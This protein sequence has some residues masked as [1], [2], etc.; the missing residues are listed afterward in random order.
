MGYLV[1]QTRVASL[2]VGGNDYTSS[3]VSWVAN[4]ASVNK[5]GYMMTDGELI[6]GQRQGA[7]DITDYDRGTFKRGTPV[8]LRMRDQSGG[9]HTHPRGLLYIISVS[10]D[11]EAEKLV[12]DLGCKIALGKLTDDYEE[13]LD[14]APLPLDKSQENINSIGANFYTNGEF[15]WMDNTGELRTNK[16][17]GTDSSAGIQGGAWTSVLGT[18]TL[19]VNPLAGGKPIPDQIKLSYDTPLDILPTDQTG[20]VDTT[21]TT[22]TYFLSY[23]AIT[24]ERIPKEE[25]CFE[26]GPDGRETPIGCIE[27]A[28]GIVETEQPE[29]ESGC[30]NTPPPPEG[31]TPEGETAKK[32][33]CNSNYKSVPSPTFVGVLRT[34]IQV[35]E[36]SAPGAQISRQSRV[37][38]GPSFELNSQYYSD[39]FAYCKAVYAYSCLPDGACPFKGLSN[40]KQG[41]QETIYYY[42]AEANNLIRT[43]QDTYLTKLSAA[44]PFNWR[45]GIENGVP[46]LFN[47]NIS[48][49]DMYRSERVITE[50]FQEANTNVQITTRFTSMAS[51]GVGINA[52]NLD[53]L[54][55]IKTTEKRVSS[56]TTTLDIRPDSINTV[57]TKTETEEI[58]IN[59]GPD[60]Y[61]SSPEQAGPYIIEEQVPIPLLYENDA[62]CRKI[63]KKYGEYL[64]RF[65]IGDLYG[66]QISESLRDE[67]LTSWYPGMPF[68]YVDPSADTIIALRMDGCSWGVNSE[69]ANV[70][71]D[72]VWIGKSSGTLVIGD[73]L[74]GNAEPN[75]GGTGTTP[76]PPT[77]P[78]PPPSIDNDVVYESLYEEVNVEFWM[79]HIMEAPGADGVVPPL[80]QEGDLEVYME[81]SFTMFCSGFIVAA[82]GLLVVD[83][84][85]GLLT[86]YAGN[87][88]TDSATIIDPDLFATA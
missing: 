8:V 44:Q 79:E 64:R 45:N 36:Y 18:T 53:A 76:T 4:D 82:G 65:Y 48:V 12:C 83:G 40:V 35:S 5:N 69:V 10:Y 52:A 51:R 23:P 57:S 63:A 47:A 29:V 7:A 58:K 25:E 72:G 75:M 42:G 30:G 59:L 6:L 67:I 16:F 11:V 68:R 66:L 61:I 62:Q 41:Y 1:Q 38:Y 84:G 9:V 13:F 15:L 28:G 70:V 88:I 56:S 73:N 17:F 60:T 54:A 27:D 78:S 34:E 49:T 46:R 77:A 19:G 71:A 43:V 32:A 81:T 87:I 31:S 20:R 37:T 22:S 14:L 21:T 86:E 33:H 80:P 2:T 55:G 85:G 24:Y 3:L 39:Q 26:I 50:Y 74:T